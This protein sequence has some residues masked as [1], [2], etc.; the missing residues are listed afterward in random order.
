MKRVAIVYI[1]L[2]ALIKNRW[3]DAPFF[4]P[5]FVYLTFSQCLLMVYFFPGH[6]VWG[7]KKVK[8][9][10]HIFFECLFRILFRG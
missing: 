9:G 5:S 3:M 2:S 4:L 8:E 7:S 10:R 1:R 6:E